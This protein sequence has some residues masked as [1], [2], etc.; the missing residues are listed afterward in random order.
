M[1]LQR[2]SICTATAV[3]AIESPAATVS[4]CCG[5][6]ANEG[7]EIGL[8]EERIGKR[9]REKRMGRE[10]EEDRRGLKVV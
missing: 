6:L 9:V 1:P 8:K 4:S 5:L 3:S 10:G 7:D 2:I